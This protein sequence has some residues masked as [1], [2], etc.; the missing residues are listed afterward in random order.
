MKT[1]T[2]NARLSSI[3]ALSLVMLACGQAPPATNGPGSVPVEER[4]AH[5]TSALTPVV[6]IEGEEP[7]AAKLEDRMRQLAVPGVSIAVISDGEIEWARGFGFA[8]LETRR[9]V[10]P[11]TLFQA[12]SISK[13]VAALASLRLVDRG[14]VDLDAPVNDRLVS[15]KVPD[16]ELTAKTPVTLR[17]LLTHTAGLTVNGFPGYG[18][19]EEVP[20]TVGVLDGEGNTDPV[21][22]DT[23]P[24]TIWRYSGGGTTVAQLLVEDV[25]GRPFEE[26]MAETVLGP[27][28]M[29]SST[30]AQPLPEQLRDIAATGYHQNGEAVEGRYHTYPE[31]AAAGLWTT[32]SDLARYLI[33]AQKGW[34]TG[35]HPVLSAGLV[36]EM[37]T[38]GMGSWGLGPEIT[39]DG[40]RFGHGGSN[41]GF[42]CDMT[43]FFE[44][45]QGAAVMTNGDNGNQLA[46]ELMLAIAAEYGWSS[47]QHIRKTV[48]ELPD[49]V[50]AA[51]EGSYTGEVGEL[52]MVGRDGR[53]VAT[54]IAEGAPEPMELEFAPESRTS[55]FG[56]R[57]G[58]E[59]TVQWNDDGTVAGLKIWVYE[60][61]KVE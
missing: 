23:E 3:A 42:K 17:Q 44:G 13:P 60:F 56:P 24:G 43:A 54:V 10:T 48:A 47:P 45:G 21:R 50:W 52:R 38:P 2:V 29:S 31:Q 25:T 49:E 51:L 18:P 4:I 16:N 12:A 6:I 36:R 1:Q 39:G 8:D 20:D 27:L 40:E 57:D 7:V 32:P 55:F 53:L 9:P 58:M 30:Y 14:L 34:R 61:E 22:V 15:W 11:E 41:D 33:A 26:V 19:D 5:I 28:G 59:A 46:A 37:L 35:E